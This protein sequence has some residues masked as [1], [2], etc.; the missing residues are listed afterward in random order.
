MGFIFWPRSARFVA[1]RPA[2]LPTHCRRVGVFV[3]EDIDRVLAIADAYRLD[4]IQLHGHES[5]DYLRRL[6]PVNG[7]TAAVIKA[8]P[9]ATAAD[10]A[11]TAPYAGLADL[12]L[13]DTKVSSSVHS[14]GVLATAASSELPGGTGR[15][16]DWSVLSAYSGQTPFLLSGGIGPGDAPRLRAAF[17]LDGFPVEKCAGLDLNSRF[18][19]APGLKDVALLHRFLSEINSQIV[20]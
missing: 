7:G 3:D 15:H 16:F 18:E 11:A 6:R 19:L 5:P 12:F 2:Y 9:V 1:H 8:F 13:F 10:L 20:K 17:A 14:G 4:Y